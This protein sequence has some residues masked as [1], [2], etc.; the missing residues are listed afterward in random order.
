MRRKRLQHVADTVCHMFCGWRQITSKP[1]LVRLGSGRLEFDLLSGRA[2]HDEH[3][4]DRLAVLEELYLWM[5]DDLRAHKIPLTQIEEARLEVDLQ[6]AVVG[7]RDTA[8]EFFDTATQRVAG[9][10]MHRCTITCRSRVR[11]SE[12]DYE[13]EYEE[14][15]HWPVGWPASG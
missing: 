8:E 1:D 6:F 15:E 4:I 11:T 5:R 13:S 2:W 10:E 3:E 14:T 12:A 9:G 7:W